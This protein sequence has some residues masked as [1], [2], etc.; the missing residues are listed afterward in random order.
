MSL[1][2]KAN[3]YIWLSI[4]LH[5]NPTTCYPP[6]ITSQEDIFMSNTMTTRDLAMTFYNEFVENGGDVYDPDSRFSKVMGEIDETLFELLDF[7]T[8]ND[9]EGK[10][11][12][13]SG[14]DVIQH[15]IWGFEKA[16]EVCRLVY[17]QKVSDQ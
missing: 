17:G 4:Q 9:L 12:T 13:M 3:M 8:A 10:I 7:K 15:Y 14:E 2:F 16:L 5:Q 6:D 11:L 1:R